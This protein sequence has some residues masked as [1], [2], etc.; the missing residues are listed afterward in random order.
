[1][2]ETHWLAPAHIQ[3]PTSETLG[4]VSHM[5][6]QAVMHIYLSIYVSVHLST[7]RQMK[8]QRCNMGM[9]NAC[10]YSSVYCEVTLMTRFYNTGGYDW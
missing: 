8:R 1:M 4:H 5:L 7:Y 2:Q 9:K 10:L 6:L 3:C